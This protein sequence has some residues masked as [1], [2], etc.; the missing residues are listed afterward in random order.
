MARR[1][2]LGLWVLILLA[3]PAHADLYKNDTFRIFADFRARLEADW[4]SQDAM[5]VER[6]DRTRFR[7]RVRVGFVHQPDDRWEFGM[8]LRSGN[9]LSQQS[10]HVT[11]LD[12]DD[13]DTGPTDF[14][15]DRWY[16][17]STFK[18]G[19]W[20][21]AGR[22]SLPFWKQNELVWDDD[23][24]PAG[25][26]VGH[27]QTIGKRGTLGFQ[28]GYFTLPE[29][30]NEF[31]GS[32]LSAQGVYSHDGERLDVTVAAGLLNLDADPIGSG[33]ILL[34]GNDMRDYRLQVVSA[35]LKL[36]AGGRPLRV[37]GDLIENSQDY[38]GDPD[39]DRTSGWVGSLHWG[40]TKERGD[41]LLAWYVARIERLAVNSSFS[42]DD[43][44]RWG[45]GPQTRASD[46]RGHELR[47]AYGLGEGSNLV[48]RLYL[49][50]ALSSV[51]DGSR[52][53][54]DYNKRF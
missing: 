14:N 46:F 33:T 53:R 41:W 37:G 21:S 7:V 15:F 43:W 22:N 23:V 13:N 9:E 47:F 52:L 35:Q 39:A 50:E 17:K 26:G 48:A 2:L 54:V 36:K 51:E 32:L 49:V 45:N 18:N 44:V 10:P 5:G 6:D 12:F 30:M 11:L 40:A 28:G 3:S 42:Q 25:V 27:Q 19:V 16:V 31:F 24:T 34:N 8:R 29:G 38:P 20:A 4:D 1:C